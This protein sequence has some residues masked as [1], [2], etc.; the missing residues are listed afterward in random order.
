[1]GDWSKY[2]WR[3]V[4]DI[5]PKVAINLVIDAHGCRPARIV[6]YRDRDNFSKRHR[7]V[8]DFDSSTRARRIVVADL[9]QSGFCVVLLKARIARVVV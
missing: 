3:A 2:R 1:M 5:D 9:I 4:K 6:A 7:S 8:M